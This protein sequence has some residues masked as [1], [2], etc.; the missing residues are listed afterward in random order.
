MK[1]NE[2]R[3]IMYRGKIMYY[4]YMSHYKEKLTCHACYI[5]AFLNSIYLFP[6]NLIKILKTK[7]CLTT[8]GLVCTAAHECLSDIEK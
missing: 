4:S 1:S 6:E 5:Y 2:Y 7:S 8:L 3:Y